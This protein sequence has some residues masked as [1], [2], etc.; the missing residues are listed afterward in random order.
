MSHPELVDEIP[1]GLIEDDLLEDDLCNRMLNSL[2]RVYKH[3]KELEEKDAVIAELGRQLAAAHESGGGPG[4]VSTSSQYQV[5]LAQVQRE[6]DQAL[7]D[8]AE[9]QQ[10]NADLEEYKKTIEQ[11]LDGTDKKLVENMYTIQKLNRDKER[12]DQ[13]IFD[14][15]EAARIVKDMVQ[16]PH[17]GFVDSRS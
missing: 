11:Q 16:P 17:P 15:E 12:R 14:L 2:C 3:H 8:C 6:S 13:E 9:L 5:E 4:A 1:V 10:S 7:Q